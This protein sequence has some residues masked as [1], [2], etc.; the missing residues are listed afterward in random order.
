MDTKNNF[1]IFMIDKY[2]SVFKCT[3][4]VWKALK[5]NIIFYLTLYNIL[6]FILC[7][8]HSDLEKNNKQL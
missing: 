6:L 4:N 8:H 7:Y 3:Q 1:Y 5:N 2:L